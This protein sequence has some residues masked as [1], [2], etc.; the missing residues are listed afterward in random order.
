MRA[1]VT[2]SAGFI[3]R[4]MASR[5][6]SDGYDVLGVDP[7]H[8][9]DHPWNGDCR[10]IFGAVTV[11]FDLVVH[12]AAT[13]PAV[14]KRL[15]NGLTV[16]YDLVL[17][18]LMFQWALRERPGKIVYFSSTAA[19]PVEINRPVVESDIDLDDLRQPDNLYGLTKLVGEV[20]AREAVK[21]GLDVLV[22]RPQSGYGADQS[23]NYPFPSFIERAKNRE[24]PFE[25]WGSGTQSR[26]FV[27]VDDIV[28]A[29]MVFLA[30]DFRGPVNIGTGIT[31][32][33]YDLAAQVCL[34]EGYAPKTT[35]RLDKPECA[36]YHC[37]DTTLMDK[38][39]TAKISLQDG[40]RDAL[41]CGL[42]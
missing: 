25:I 8:P 6:Q 7:A 30:A 24:D 40:I 27:H 36:H 37:A 33:L 9:L 21:A 38:F 2:G 14:D 5:L 3:G 31:T 28:G 34:T 26:D 4:H 32:T 15:E 12:C 18:G 41:T 23:L 1:L 22:V 16:A 19:Y 17:D 10:R 11:E 42:S 35:A 13:I 39:Y 20:Q 29:T